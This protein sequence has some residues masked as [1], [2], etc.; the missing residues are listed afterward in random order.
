[1]D[2]TTPWTPPT[3][4]LTSGRYASYWNAFLFLAVYPSNKAY[5]KIVQ[6]CNLLWYWIYCYFFLMFTFSAWKT[7]NLAA[8]GLIHFNPW[9]TL[10]KQTFGIWKQKNSFHLVCVAKLFMWC[11]SVGHVWVNRVIQCKILV[12]RE[13][14]R[15]GKF[16][17][18]KLGKGFSEKT[19]QSRIN[20]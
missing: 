5:P 10:L 20:F 13:R 8:C 3:P 9:W 15:L 19:L 2:T 16:M 6:R 7:R 18:W 12:Y 4:R 17:L 14:E 11:M 1:M